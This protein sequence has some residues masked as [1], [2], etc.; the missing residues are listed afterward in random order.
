M[1]GLLLPALANR[2]GLLADVK[3]DLSGLAAA[4]QEKAVFSEQHELLGLE[5]ATVSPP[6]GVLG[7]AGRTGSSAAGHHLRAQ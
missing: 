1:D 5:P 6:G 2:H 7:W 3:G 4:G